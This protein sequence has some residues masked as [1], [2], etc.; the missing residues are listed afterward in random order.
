MKA[1]VENSELFRTHLHKVFQ[2]HYDIVKNTFEESVENFLVSLLPIYQAPKPFTPG[3]LQYYLNLFPL[4]N[5]MS[6]T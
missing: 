5:L 2:P 4:K 3:E 1:D 6:W